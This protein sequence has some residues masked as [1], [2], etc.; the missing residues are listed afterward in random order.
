M[1]V[2]REEERDIRALEHEYDEAWTAGDL[3][4]LVG[5]FAPD[6]V[7]VT[8]YGDVM[9]GLREIEL[10]LRT[11]M[12]E[13]TRRT[14]ASTIVRVHLVTAEVAVVDGRA[15]L[16]AGGDQSG[17]EGQLLHAFTD[18]LVRRGG[19]WRIAQVRAYTFMD[20]RP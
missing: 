6:A 4:R 14:H 18:I 5:L 1:S 15:L 12:E 2:F 19:S 7:I 11:I 17:R 16:D 8:P 3:E 20:D 10:G 9:N 13:P